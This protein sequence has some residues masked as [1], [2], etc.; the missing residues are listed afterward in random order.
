MQADAGPFP[1]ANPREA[2]GY[3]APHLPGWTLG[4]SWLRPADESAATSTRQRRR[5]TAHEEFGG[6]RGDEQPP[7]LPQTAA[8]QERE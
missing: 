3:G 8:E 6:E 2:K 4:S 5:R 1:G 7:A